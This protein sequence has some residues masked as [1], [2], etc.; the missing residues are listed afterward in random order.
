[1]RIG[2]EVVDLESQVHLTRPVHPVGE[3]M[4]ARSR[5]PFE[6]G[7]LEPFL[8]PSSS[9][10]QQH[11]RREPGCAG[12]HHRHA[13]GF[14]HAHRRH[15]GILPRSCGATARPLGHPRGRSTRSKGKDGRVR[16]RTPS[17]S[18]PGTK[19]EGGSEGGHTRAR[20]PRR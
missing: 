18:E 9:L 2:G 1:M 5:L 13:C 17:L 14:R 6:E 11:R 4:S 16:T 10:L 3:R 15:R 19:G 7:H 20:R 12:S 8:V